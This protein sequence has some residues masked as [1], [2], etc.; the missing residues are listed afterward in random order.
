[1]AF[2]QQFF[3]WF[4][5]A[6][7]ALIAECLIYPGMAQPL[8]LFS[9]EPA[10]T[11]DGWSCSPSEGGSKD[12]S[13]LASTAPLPDRRPLSSYSQ[14]EIASKL[15]WVSEPGSNRCG[16]YYQDKPIPKNTEANEDELN[17]HADFY[18]YSFS[19][20]SLFRGG[21]SAIQANQ[22][23]TSDLAYMNRSSSYKPESLDLYGNVTLRQQGQLITG[24]IGKYQVNYK[25]GNLKNTLYR[26][27]RKTED[28]NLTAWGSAKTIDQQSPTHFLLSDASYS[29]CTPA[30]PFWRIDAKKIIL[31]R[32]TGRGE[33]IHNVLSIHNI[34]IFYSP[35]FNFPID[36]RRKTGLLT[37]TYGTSSQ[38][39]YLFSLPFYWNIAPN[40]DLLLTPTYL[41]LRRSTFF[42]TEFRYLSKLSESKINYSLIP[43]DQTFG[44]FKETAPTKYAAPEASV[45][46]L[47]QANTSR[48]AFSLED[49]TTF[50]P[51]WKTSFNYADVSDDYFPQ[52]FS[53][54]TSDLYTNPL[55]R[56][57]NITYESSIIS[58]D[59]TFQHYKTLHPINLAPLNNQYNSMPSISLGATAP[60]PWHNI[61]YSV[62]TNFTRFTQKDSPDP[63]QSQPVIGNRTYARPSLEYLFRPPYAELTPRIQL[64]TIRYDLTHQTLGSTANPSL[65]LPIIDTKGT[66]YFDRSVNLFEHGYRQTLEPQMYYLY[67]PYHSQNFLPLFDSSA[68][69]INYAQMFNY[70]RFSSVDRVGDANQLTTGI[71]SRIIDDNTGD[72]KFNFAA[73]QIHYFSNR[74][75]QACYGPDCPSNLP[76]VNTQSVSPLAMH[77][78]ASPNHFWTISTD[79]TWNPY[80]NAFDN[81]G[82]SLQYK[83]DNTSILNLNYDIVRVQNVDTV[84]Q[85]QQSDISGLF[86]ISNK[87]SFYGRWNYDWHD[88]ETL[89]YFTGLQYDTCCW[90]IRLV[91]GR[92]FLGTDS[93]N[94][95]LFNY[96][97]YVQ[98]ALK[99]FAN[100][101][102]SETS[103]FLQQNINGYNDRF[104]RGS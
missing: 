33:A 16:G 46:Q 13:V 40:Y 76:D 23:L 39:G 11:G 82:L 77:A 97:F 15:E 35:Y 36:K 54:L 21:V 57:A 86:P 29:T 48:Y 32:K 49:K 45:S 26:L 61:N 37:P 63:T 4:N 81:R 52:D 5:K 38:S 65:A 43:D 87:W 102:S 70:N 30:N 18:S 10:Q 19:Q 59:T 84:Y 92:S 75:V 89:Q 34:P 100:I 67:V 25:T 69:A 68:Q 80:V 22:E 50:S 2:N 28:G 7:I 101:G 53:E 60:T 98:F 44:H 62:A 51:Y 91:Q 64:H 3:K 72:E 1:M 85:V 55:S 31:D 71:M 79:A 90:A 20:R 24:D 56:K 88:K 78:A 94:N 6:L 47:Q 74:K 95:N 42:D 96:T 83:K 73:A 14:E 17:I 58:F 93:N 103:G 27:D 8:P 9:C 41:Q 66:L 12:P 104:G 99:G